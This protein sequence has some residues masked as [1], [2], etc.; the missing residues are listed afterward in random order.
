MLIVKTEKDDIKNSLLR[1]SKPG[2]EM[3]AISPKRTNN[4]KAPPIKK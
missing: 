4:S 2:K 1:L 3:A